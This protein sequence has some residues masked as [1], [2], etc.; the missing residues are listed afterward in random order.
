MDSPVTLRSNSTRLLR[1]CMFVLLLLAAGCGRRVEE[2]HRAVFDFADRNRDGAV[3]Q[4]EFTATHPE[5]NARAQQRDFERADRNA[6]GQL[7]FEEFES[8]LDAWHRVFWGLGIFSALSFVG[9]LV[10]IPVVVARLPVD[11]FVAPHEAADW[12]SSSFLRR[13]WLVLKNLLGIMLICGGIIMLVL[14]GQGVLTILLGVALTDIPGKWRLMRALAR[15]PNVMKALNWMRQRA[16]KPP[17]LPPHSKD[18]RLERPVL[19]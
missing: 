14:P 1:W 15:R 8:T 19:S 11:H 17:L 9:S 5:L 3:S 4:A 12:V 2:R 13:G 6:D 16:R 7:D 18:T 10:A